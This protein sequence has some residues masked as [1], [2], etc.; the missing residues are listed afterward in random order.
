MRA[1]RKAL[2][3]SSSTAAPALPAPAEPWDSAAPPSPLPALPSDAPDDSGPS[4][5][6]APQQSF[7]VRVHSAS[8]LPSS[9][10][11]VSL[12]LSDASGRI[13]SKKALTVP[14]LHSTEPLWNRRDT[15]A[16]PLSPSCHASLTRLRLAFSVRDLG[17]RPLPGDVLLV[18]LYT[19]NWGALVGAAFCPA[20]LLA[21]AAADFFSPPPAPAPPAPVTLLLRRHLEHSPSPSGTLPSVTVS[22]PTPLSLPLSLAPPFSSK[23]V[24]LL[25]HGQSR[26]NE[27]QRSRRLDAMVAFDHPLTRAGA[28]QAIA[29]RERWRC[30]T[31]AK[32]KPVQFAQPEAKAAGS[33]LER[34]AADA[35]EE[36]FQLARLSDSTKPDADAE[37]DAWHAEWLASDFLATSPLTRALQTALLAL[38]GHPAADRQGIM[39]LRNARE[40][41]GVGSLDSI[42]RAVGPE[43]LV[44]AQR[45]LL[46]EL[47][48]SLFGD[49][50][51]TACA[52]SK[53]SYN[54]AV[55]EWWTAAD[56]VDNEA[57]VS[58]R[59]SDLLCSLQ[60]SSLLAAPSSSCSTSSSNAA[61]LVGHS[62]LFR[63]LY[64]RCEQHSTAAGLFAAEQPEMAQR[65]RE[66]KLS[67][68][69]VLGLRLEFSRG[70]AR[71][72]DAR[73][74]F[75]ATVVGG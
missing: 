23:T 27:A 59:V 33:V 47:P 46:E 34:D 70:R 63:E 5:H 39:L 21:P 74:L 25:R 22:S 9:A 15:Q 31:A 32:A 8:G 12:A 45:S 75:G 36:L 3:S 66:G 49:S 43:C 16:S 69:G 13:R 50:V 42:G 40:V 11:F 38:Q 48:E 30:D 41:K 19:P 7:L 62:L 44:R 71:I 2:G 14:V 17:V 26:W 54:D 68:A 67:N 35:V 29:L 4:S 55:S 64:R 20:S 6:G 37:L 52:A 65:L 60:Y 18:E 53:I 73:L 61:I 24:F 72:R 1:L 57:D 28:E 51:A 10:S 56:D 58:E